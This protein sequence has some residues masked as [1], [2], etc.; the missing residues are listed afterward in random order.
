MLFLAAHL[1]ATQIIVEPGFKLLR[2][3]VIMR[4]FVSRKKELALYSDVLAVQ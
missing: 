2:L 1:L 3:L 4:F